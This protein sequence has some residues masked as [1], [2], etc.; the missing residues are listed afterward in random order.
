MPSKFS[1]RDLTHRLAGL[2]GW[3]RRFAAFLAGALS[4]LALA[5]FFISPVLWLTL[6]ALVW[7]L[8]GAIG[9]DKARANQRWIKWPELSAAAVGWWWGFGYFLAGLFWIGEAFLVEA[10]RFAVLMPFAVV[11]LPAGLAI[12]YA[13]ATASVARFWHTGTYRVLALALSLGAAEW[14]RGHVL[15]GFPWNILGYA[16]TSPLPLMQSAAVLGIYGLT[17]LAVVIFAF[18][19]VLWCDAASPRTKT[20]AVA[21]AALPLLVMSIYGQIRL[22]TAAS[23]MV[24][25]VKIRIV[26][27][28]I[29]QREKWIRG[30]QENIFRQHLDQ[31]KR[32]PSGKDDDLA[33]ISHVVWPEA[34]MPFLPLDTPEAL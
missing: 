4:V 10:G 11:L 23:D 34:A 15:S 24:P 27:P 8:D 18:P 9:D 21:I 28:S 13:A 31:S 32:D 20:L 2:T 7:L 19:L 16:L 6:P 12:F 14:L 26:Q 3:R 17:L 5:P 25:G 33:G 22:S 30:N 29:P 1:L